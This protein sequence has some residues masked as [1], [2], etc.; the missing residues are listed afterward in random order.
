MIIDGVEWDVYE[1]MNA[2]SRSL[3]VRIMFVF[4]NS[5]TMQRASG[6]V[7]GCDGGVF[8]HWFWT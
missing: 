4:M 7:V 1:S 5:V 6:A 8:V 3:S 2:L